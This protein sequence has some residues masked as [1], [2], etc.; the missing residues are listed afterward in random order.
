MYRDRG[1]ENKSAHPAAFALHKL[2]ISARRTKEL[3][4]HEEI[5]AAF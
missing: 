1:T 5:K 3:N 2:I 4:P